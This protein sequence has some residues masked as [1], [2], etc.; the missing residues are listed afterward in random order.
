MP[1]I[2]PLTYKEASVEA[3]IVYEE[4]VQEHGRM[5]NMKQT[6][7][8]SPVALLAALTW[9]DL[10][11]ELTPVLGERLAIIYSQA[12]AR[13]SQCE[14]CDTFCRRVIIDGGED[15][16]NLVLNE[17]E[18]TLVDYG[19]QLV[20]NSNQVSD[21]LYRRLTHYFTAKQIVDLTVFAG[22]MMLN[23]I[24]N[25]ALQVEVDDYLEPYRAQP[26]QWLARTGPSLTT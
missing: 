26:E 14:L 9:Y 7:L 22:L 2:Q 5:T 10:Y 19:R 13:Q 20:V 1:R 6:M 12:V 23:N 24:F 4:V 17:L 18:Q 11:N 16:D 15:P 25:N 8:H 21:E 3:Q